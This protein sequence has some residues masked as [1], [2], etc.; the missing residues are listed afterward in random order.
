M[1]YPD[2]PVTQ[3]MIESEILRL[4]GL[5]EKATTEIGKRA[6]VA[7]AKDAAYKKANAVAYL[8]AEGK[9][10]GDREAVAAIETDNEYTERRAA[11]AVLLAAQ[12]AGRNYRAQLDAL[13]SLNSNLRALVTS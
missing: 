13:R 5:A 12:E 4:C 6:R 2:S 7:A 3:H 8:K 11:E 10:V 9:T 1:T